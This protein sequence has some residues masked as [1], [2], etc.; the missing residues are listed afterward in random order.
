MLIIKKAISKRPTFLSLILDKKFHITEIQQYDRIRK[1]TKGV[2]RNLKKIGSFLGLNIP[3]TTYV[4]RHSFATVLKRSGVNVAII[5][6]ALGHTSLST[7]QFYLDSFDNE[8]IDDAMKAMIKVTYEDQLN[9]STDP[10]EYLLAL[11]KITNKGSALLQERV[12]YSKVSQ[13]VEAI[14]ENICECAQEYQIVKELNPDI[15]KNLLNCYDLPVCDHK[16]IQLCDLLLL[17]KRAENVKFV[18]ETNNR[19]TLKADEKSFIENV[20][21]E[22]LFQYLQEKR[23]LEEYAS[24]IM[25]TSPTPPKSFIYKR[26]KNIYTYA[27]N[28]PQPVSINKSNLQQIRDKEMMILEDNSIAVV[29]R[30]YQRLIQKGF[31]KPLPS[32]TQIGTKPACFI[33]DTLMFLGYFSNDYSSYEKQYQINKAKRDRIK[34]LIRPNK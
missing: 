7:T 3:L 25:W 16:L 2:N 14:R 29:N 5:S 34:E 30:L 11:I 8:Q 28:N 21:Q 9:I 15:F 22:K 32:R 10:I 17:F 20:I 33:Y 13:T 19:Q 23:K 31:V 18:L 26:N 1:V 24:Y 12:D 6:E 27:A 4:A